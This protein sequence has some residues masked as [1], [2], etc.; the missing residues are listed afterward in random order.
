M[1]SVVRFKRKF[2]FGVLI[3]SGNYLGDFWN[4]WLWYYGVRIFVVLNNYVI[5]VNFVGLLVRN[6]YIFLLLKLYLKL[7]EMLLMV[8]DSVVFEKEFICFSVLLLW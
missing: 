6:I 3:I 1:K 8:C 7:K 4:V 2:V 5:V